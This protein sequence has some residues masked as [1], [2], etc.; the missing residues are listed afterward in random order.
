MSPYDRIL[1]PIDGSESAERGLMEAIRLAPQ[2]G[3]RLHLLHVIDANPALVDA[4]S[5]RDREKLLLS[6]RTLAQDLLG[7][8][9]LL[10]G[11][12]GVAADP[13]VRETTS[14]RVADLVVDEAGLAD[15]GLIVMGTHGRRGI[16]RLAMGSDAEEVVRK[17]PVP[18]LL[19]RHPD[20]VPLQAGGSAVATAVAGGAQAHAATHG[21][22]CQPRS[23]R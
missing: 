5:A 18:V 10:A 19:V 3:A 6:M 17:S 12:A 23:I 14:Q 2:L 7:R 13:A 15:C 8:A 16:S 20:V 11:A 21:I 22:G 4:A 1:V 9:Q